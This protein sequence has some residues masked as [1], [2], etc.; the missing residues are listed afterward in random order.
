MNKEFNN[1]G[2]VPP[3]AVDYEEILL[4]E[5]LQSNESFMKSIQILRNSEVFYKPAHQTIWDSMVA[6]TD[7][8]DR[9]DIATL[10]RYMI[11][12]GK[13]DEI[14]G[15]YYIAQLTSK[16]VS[17]YLVGVE[18]LCFV[19]KEKHILRH[20]ISFSNDLS[21]KAFEGT[22]TLDEYMKMCND[23]LMEV[24]KMVFENTGG[25]RTFDDALDNARRD[26]NTRIEKALKGELS[27]L[28]TGSRALN[29]LTN[30]FRNGDLIVI[31]GRPSMGKT[32]IVLMM[33]WA[34]SLAQNFIE[35]F[36]L[37]MS[38]T[39][40]ADRLIIG[41]SGVNPHRYKTGTTTEDEINQI[42][43]TISEMKGNKYL[44]IDDNSNVSLS[45]I[46]A[47]ATLA[48]SKG[49]LNGIVIDYLQLME[50]DEKANAQNRE[51][52][53]AI[54]TRGLKLLAKQLDVPVILL[55]QLNRGV[56]KRTGDAK[57]PNLSDLRESGAIE[58]DAD[59][60]IFIHRPERYGITEDAEG[61]SLIGIIQLVIAKYRD[62]DTG[63]IE[64]R[65]NGSM[66]KI[67][68]IDEEIDQ[69]STPM[70]PNE[71]IQPNLGFDDNPPF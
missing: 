46:R 2:L 69:E 3:H 15:H 42:D 35:V 34:A 4:G 49:E 19:I 43:T 18:K 64:L 38:D 65:H 36:S 53:V 25:N 1:Y 9:V 8:G 51:R 66:T 28:P 21:K 22:T 60:V 32:A 47:K 20:G 63:I 11:D 52:E 45:S 24:S 41:K 14:G 44:R 56:E 5:C 17:S 68:D 70:N 54:T 50:T 39:K 62:G 6:L 23:H 48:K 71:G 57:I 29:E 7:Q 26:L 16:A 55:A 31:A 33:I 61:N 12:H 30:G 67:F 58:Q 13:I 37:E 10:T 27:G 59:M 40:L